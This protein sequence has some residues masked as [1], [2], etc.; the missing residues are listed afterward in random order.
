MD[1]KTPD[2]QYI[3][4]YRI[5]KELISTRLSTIYIGHDPDLDVHVAIKVFDPDPNKIGSRLND[6]RELWQRRFAEEPKV[7]ASLDHPN[8]IPVKYMSFLEDDRPYFVMPFMAA[9]LPFEMGIDEVDK[10]VIKTLAEKEKPKRL[11]FPRAIEV[12]NQLLDALDLVHRAGFV[13]RDIK[14]SNILLTKLAGGTVKLCDFGMVKNPDTCLSEAGKWIGTRNYISPEQYE[15]AAEADARADIYSV[16]V[17]AYRMLAGR[18]P[19]DHTIPLRE[20]AP[21][22]P[23]RLE[24]L[25]DQCMSLDREWRPK[26]AG[27]LSNKLQ[28]CLK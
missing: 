18:L 17:M 20:F 21:E 23:E 27:E 14:P 15:N 11:S 19:A 12:L 9:N 4:K 5:R 7:I 25:L 26:D 1:N 3:G 10:E 28:T 22:V 8:I 16:G 2:Q 6:R 24:D 13:H